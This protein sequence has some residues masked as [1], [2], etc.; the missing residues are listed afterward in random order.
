M[1]ITIAVPVTFTTAAPREGTR[2]ALTFVPTEF[3]VPEAMDDEAPIVAKRFSQLEVVGSDYRLHEGNLYGARVRR[4]GRK[5]QADIAY[6]MSTLIGRSVYREIEELRVDD[7]YPRDAKDMMVLVGAADSDPTEDY[8]KYTRI[9]FERAA[10]RRTAAMA[11]ESPDF[12]ERRDRA[13][14]V[15][16]EAISKLLIVDGVRHKKT[17]GI[18]IAVNTDYNRT[19]EVSETE[20]WDGSLWT[21]KP[22][23]IM[24]STDDMKTHYFAYADR[25]EALSFA[26]EL[27][28]TLGRRVRVDD[29]NIA[30]FVPAEAFPK[31]NMRWAELV[32]SSMVVAHHTGVEVARRIRNQE[33]SIFTDDRAIRY[34]FDRLMEAMDDTDAFGEPHDRLEVAARDLLAILR[35]NPRDIKEKYRNFVER[36]GSAFDHLET[37][38]SRWDDRPLEIEVSYR[39]P[40]M[41]R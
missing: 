8:N 32:R 25:D 24:P 28:A 11:A 20:M 27:G 5:S 2:T 23:Q 9:A 10:N 13:V 36:W 4:D 40:G 33:S 12:E 29:D 18:V 1:R 19:I 3:E 21:Q 17:P 38:L 41:A 34:A 37:A 14:A 31:Q 22:G 35:R 30:A 15:I 7:L 39:Q 16:S 6:E 26:E